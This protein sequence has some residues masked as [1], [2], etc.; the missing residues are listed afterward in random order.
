MA[1]LEAGSSGDQEGT[2]VVEVDTERWQTLGVSGITDSAE[3]GGYPEG[4]GEKEE[5]S[6]MTKL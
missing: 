3:L 2:T 4:V 1:R 6:E 5:E